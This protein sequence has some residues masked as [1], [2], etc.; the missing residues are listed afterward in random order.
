MTTRSIASG[1]WDCGPPISRRFP[2]HKV[3]VTSFHLFNPGYTRGSPRDVAIS[4]RIPIKPSMRLRAGSSEVRTICASSS[5]RLFPDCCEIEA[6]SAK[7]KNKCLIARRAAFHRLHHA[8]RQVH[9][10]NAG[11]GPG[12]AG[13]RV[14]VQPAGDH[15]RAFPPR[16]PRPGRR[17]HPS[18]AREN[19][20][21]GGVVAKSSCAARS[22]SCPA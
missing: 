15:E 12:L 14:G 20:R 16:A 10:E 8:H 21:A 3:R 11:G 19:G 9:A 13:C 5:L 22:R 1:S 18:A 2:L 6:G 17:H 7:A 4:L